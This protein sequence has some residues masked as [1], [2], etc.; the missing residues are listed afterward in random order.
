MLSRSFID[1]I[2]ELRLPEADLQQALIEL[3]PEKLTVDDL[4]VLIEAVRSKCTEPDLSDCGVQTLDCSGTGGSGVGPFN[5]STAAAFVLAAGGVRVAKFGNRASRSASGSFDFLEVLGV[6]FSNDGDDAR[7][8]LKKSGLA[9][10]Y[11]PAF[12]PQLGKLAP[13]RKAVG[14]R[15]YRTVFNFIGPLLNPVRPE[16]RLMGVSG[17]PMHTLISSYL[18]QN[19]ESKA[20][21][22]VTG[23]SGLDEID[24]IGPTRLSEIRGTNWDRCL[25]YLPRTPDSP[26][27]L[28]LNKGAIPTPE[29]NARRFLKM[30]DGQDNSSVDYQGVCLNAGA[31]FYLSGKAESLVQGGKLAGDMFASGAVR[32]KIEELRSDNVQLL[33]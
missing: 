5:T 10:L 3:V 2:L 33:A 31:G 32:Q 22:V 26:P 17:L 6:P 30:V 12:Y 16:W 14:A 13:H 23:L 20:C 8:R 24:V 18:V 25:L 1:N 7:R 28:R 19:Q 9:F 29:E 27:M 15:G 11:A 4:K 21:M